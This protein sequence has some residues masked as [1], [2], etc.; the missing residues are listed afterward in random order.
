MRKLVAILLAVI[1]SLS[2]TGLVGC[3]GEN[4]GGGDGVSVGEFLDALTQKYTSYKMKIEETEFTPSEDYYMGIDFDESA[5]KF[6]SAGS[7]TYTPYAYHY[8]F[9][10]QEFYLERVYKNGV[11]QDVNKVVNDNGAWEKTPLNNYN[12]DYSTWYYHDLGDRQSHIS[13]FAEYM[14]YCAFPYDEYPNGYAE[15]MDST[16]ELKKFLKN[17]YFSFERIATDIFTDEKMGIDLIYG[18]GATNTTYPYF[19][20]TQEYVPLF[21]DV[22]I[23]KWK[24]KF[25]D[26]EK[27]KEVICYYLIEDSNKILRVTVS[28]FNKTDLTLPFESEVNK[29][30]ASDEKVTSLTQEQFEAFMLAPS[31]TNYT[32]TYEEYNGDTL[33][34]KST[35]YF[36][37]NI[38]YV[39]EE[40]YEEGSAT[41][42]INQFYYDYNGNAD[43]IPWNYTYIGS[44]TGKAWKAEQFGVDTNAIGRTWAATQPFNGEFGFE[45]FDSYYENYYYDSF[46]NNFVYNRSITNYM[47]FADGNI[48]GA[49][50]EAE[51]WDL[52]NNPY[53]IRYK[54]SNVGTTTV[55]L[56]AA[57]DVEFVD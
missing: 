22:A 42:I 20:Q 21:G 27:L 57:S 5:A 41:P 37:N 10:G 19:D 16:K 1:S 56:P 13:D 11:Y 47:T 46:Y 53:T 18:T 7:I 48:V 39:Y 40:N 29:T 31:L 51:K 38:Y 32:L 26:N 24:V 30:P 55:T 52:Y 8:D 33:I 54:L 43:D 49:Y 14:I 36:A 34:H 50:L 17:G 45:D 25:D 12:I 23:E 35:L 2:I 4:S 3:G 15:S 6:T 9:D 28:G 44:S